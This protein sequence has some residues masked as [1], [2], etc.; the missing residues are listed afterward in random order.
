MSSPDD[1]KYAKSHEWVKIDGD[2]AVIGITDHA[3][4]SLGDIT[5]VEMPQSG[6]Q[7]SKGKE[8]GVIESVKAASDLYAPVSGEVAE[9]NDALGNQPELVN[10][11]PYDQGWIVKLKNVDTA[12]LDDLMDS[13]AYDSFLESEG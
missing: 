5:F 11:S 3:Q 8:F 13:S 1:R 10:T 6:T 7:L 2:T 9:V 4:D 12:G